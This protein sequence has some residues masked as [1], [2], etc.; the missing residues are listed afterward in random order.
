[1][2]VFPV[3]RNLGW[4]RSRLSWQGALPFTK[5]IFFFL[6]FIIF[7]EN[8]WGS[9]ALRIEQRASSLF[10]CCLP[11]NCCFSAKL[12]KSHVK[13]ICTV[14]TVLQASSLCTPVFFE[15]TVLP[16]F[17]RRFFPVS[18]SGMWQWEVFWQPFFSSG[19][20]CQEDSY[21]S[22][23]QWICLLKWLFPAEEKIDSL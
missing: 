7:L 17:W 4:S 13:R 14:L 11:Y 8:L 18:C 21:I 12:V 19:D 10:Q 2:A 1:M 3:L 23:S 22:T 6:L 16:P 9:R 20:A 15:G 5:E